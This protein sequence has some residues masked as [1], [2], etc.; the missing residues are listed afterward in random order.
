MFTQ[1]PRHVV[2]RER[3]TH[4]KNLDRQKKTIKSS[5]KKKYKKI[6]FCLGGGMGNRIPLQA[7]GTLIQKILT[8]KKNL[9]K[10]KYKK[11][12]INS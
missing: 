3:H 8:G 11:N 10:T 12:F 6:A 4:L 9:Q 7:W 1:F 2:S 5:I